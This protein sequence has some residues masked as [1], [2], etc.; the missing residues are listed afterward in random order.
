MVERRPRARRQATAQAVPADEWYA[1]TDD[2]DSALRISSGLTLGEHPDGALAL[3][4]PAA[5]ARWVT[6][7]VRR[8]EASLSVLAS[9][10]LVAEDQ[11]ALD[12]VPLS[13]GLCLE[14]PHNLLRISHSIRAP[15]ATGPRLYVVAAQASV[16]ER[17]PDPAPE[18]EHVVSKPAPAE[19]QPATGLRPAL[20]MA[21]GAGL[22]GLVL[23]ASWQQLSPGVPDPDGAAPVAAQPSGPAAG[24]AGAADMGPAAGPV[25]AVR[26]GATPMRLLPLPAGAAPAPADPAEPGAATSEPL[27]SAASPADPRL[28]MARRY[29]EAGQIT[30]PPDENAV[31]LA[32]AV[33][34]DH[35]QHA[36]AMVLLGRCTTTLLDEARAHWAAGRSFAARNS[37]EEILGFNPDH[38]EARQLWAEWVGTRR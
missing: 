24:E 11:R 10:R 29:F 38:P 8:G 33:L 27:A 16:P 21:L 15:A 19:K 17:E 25:V 3:N 9:R 4:A 12:R 31:A 22:V 13:D 14:L 5:E 32:L 37:L 30:M 6:F 35:T 23:L 7:E 34:R 2:G 36:D 26:L 1:V 28:E 18:S 20:A